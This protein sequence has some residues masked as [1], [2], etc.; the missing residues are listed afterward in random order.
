MQQQKYITRAAAALC[1]TAACMAIFCCIG[2]TQARY[3]NY[4]QWRAVYQPQQQQLHSDRLAFGGQTVLLG[5]WQVEAGA[6]RM[7]AICVYSDGG[8]ANATLCCVSDQPEYI[9]ASLDR[10]EISVDS[11]GVQ[12]QLTM[13]PTEAALNLDTQTTVS[14]RI[15]LL[16]EGK[17]EPTLWATY[18]V[19]LQGVQTQQIEQAAPA[20]LTMT[21]A[22][23]FAWSECLGMHISLPAQTETLTLTMDGE[24][25]PA[26]MRYI[27]G[28]ETYM[29][30]ESMPIEIIPQSEDVSMIL[31]FSMLTQ[32]Q[33]GSICL[34]AKALQGQTVTA[35]G[36]ITVATTRQAFYADLET[37]DPVIT[38]ND[39]L[40]V[41]VCP[42]TSGLVWHLQMLTETNDG[43]AY[44]QS[45]EQ[46]YLVI[47]I[48]EDV[49]D[50][51]KQITV[52]NENAMAPAGTYRLT[53]ER[54][55][56]EQTISVV[57]M[58]FYVCY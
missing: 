33:S 19:D 57:Q 53:L 11:T 40:T 6:S 44:S 27:Y 58:L 1:A 30:G 16:P 10:T 36:E 52:S 43:I 34:Q 24:S 7:E 29:L 56:D 21:G 46:Y 14:V 50:S 49:T 55:Q 5:D 12:L 18:Q 9:A 35:A 26:G 4:S 32:P 51:Q 47:S 38:G 31:D 37:V 2:Q 54:Q 42:D 45:D 15:E 8:I 48:S 41:P 25:F 23:T 22:D 28:E 39:V 3:E 20:A 13:T 17:A